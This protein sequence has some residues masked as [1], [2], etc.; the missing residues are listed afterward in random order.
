MSGLCKRFPG[1]VALDDVGLEFEAGAV[2][3]VVGENGAGKSTLMTI[4][5]G[6][7]RPDAGTVAVNGRAVETF[8][9]HHLLHEHG[10]A[11][12]P[13]EIALCRDRTVA[14]NVLLGREPGRLPSRR[15]MVA[16]T[17]ALLDEIDTR[18]TRL[19]P[20]G[21]LS[22]AEQQLVLIVRALARQCRIVI[23]DEPTTSLTPHEVEPTVHIAA[24]AARR[25]ARRSSTSRTGCPRSSS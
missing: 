22:L 4:L 25:A 2:T 8:T 16:E 14:E 17:R 11:L 1:V 7:Q 5:A 19:Q 23:L 10:V 6:L 20:A 9:P 12:V 3:A 15:R 13:Q 21:L 24:A 18:S